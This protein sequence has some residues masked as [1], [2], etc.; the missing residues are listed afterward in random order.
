MRRIATG[1][2]VLAVHE[3]SAHNDE[4]EPDYKTKRH[5]D[6]HTLD[7]APTPFCISLQHS[8]CPLREGRT[9]ASNVSSQG[10]RQTM[11]K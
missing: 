5:K 6:L 3:P 7:V 1:V 11:I 4:K 2:T 9:T 8:V 10:C